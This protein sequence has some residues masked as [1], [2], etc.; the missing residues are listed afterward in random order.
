MSRRRGVVPAFVKSVDAGQG[1]V[2]VEYRVIDDQLESSWA[3]MASPMS[4]KSRGALFMP[5]KGDEVLVAFGD[6]EFDT[7]FVVG[8]LWNGEQVSPETTPDNRVV[9][10]PG[11]HQL[12]FEDKANDKRVILKSAGGHQ[13]T[14]ED[15]LPG[16]K[17][18]IKSTQH[19]VTLDDTAGSSN[20]TLAAGPGGA[21]S[22]EMKTT[23]PS[24][25]ITTPTGMVTVDSSGLSIQTSSA[26]TVNSAGPAT[27]NCT[28]ATV[29]ASAMTLN[30]PILS[31]NA[32][33]ATFTGVIQCTALIA[34]AISSPLYTP[35]IGNLI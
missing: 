21:I 28:A 18:E 26:I 32:A 22:I 31:V 34:N 8:C 35:G 7:P 25:T 19:T 10:T 6:G 15:K 11:G 29:N 33:M 13:I 4:G 24:V 1:R 12:R 17:I 20:I 16:R 2:K 27:I 5:E 30:T 3:P 23:P 9:V 14:L